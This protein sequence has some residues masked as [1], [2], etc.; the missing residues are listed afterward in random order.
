MS[1]TN[2]PAHLNELADAIEYA[3]ER[4]GEVLL[5]VTDATAAVEALR[6]RAK[7]TDAAC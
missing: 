3:I 4:S 1:I 5:S 2:E 7:A 6:S